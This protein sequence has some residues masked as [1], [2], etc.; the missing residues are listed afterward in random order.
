MN[1]AV[2]LLGQFAK[3]M[4]IQ[5]VISL[6]I[7]AGGAIITTLDNLPGDAWHRKSRTTRHAVI[8]VG[9]T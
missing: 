5:A 9:Y 3:V 1:R 2:K 8:P 4:Q 7:E 6:G